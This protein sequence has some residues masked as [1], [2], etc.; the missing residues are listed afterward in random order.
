MQYKYETACNAYPYHQSVSA[1]VG[2]VLVFHVLHPALNA[3]SHWEHLR[4]THIVQQ[5]Y[6]STLRH[7]GQKGT[8]ILSVMIGPIVAHIRE[9]FQWQVTKRVYTSNIGTSLFRARNWGQIH[10]VR[11]GWGVQ[12][13]DPDIIHP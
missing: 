12:I 9:N 10:E 3:S 11:G 4:D 8:Q 7:I 5:E 2:L 6:P 1:T 13:H